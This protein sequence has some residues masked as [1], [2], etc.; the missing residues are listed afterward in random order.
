[1]FYD[2]KE[3]KTKKSLHDVSFPS[4]MSLPALSSDDAQV[5]YNNPTTTTTTTPA[6]GDNRDGEKEEKSE[7]EP[8]S[9]EENSKRHYGLYGVLVHSGMTAN[10]G[11][12]FSFCRESSG[13]G[14]ELQDSLFAPWI[15]F[16]D[17]KVETSSWAEMNRILS[18]SVS[19]TVYLLLYK[20]IE[21]PIVLTTTTATT[22][23]STAVGATPIE[24]D[25]AMLLAKAMALS[26][27]AAAQKTP[28]AQ[29]QQ[30]LM[31]DIDEENSSTTT[32]L[33][34]NDTFGIYD[35]TTSISREVMYSMI[36]YTHY[37]L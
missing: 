9:K 11:H 28:K 34:N 16:N 27:S 29:D 15:K 33:H 6:S 37:L 13:K 21:A 25:E 24:E 14:L 8:P 3:Q 18:N 19:D 4:Y 23:T 31:M 22:A 30:A 26:M 10:S 1:M 7:E 17:T 12:Y 36:S 5:V 2:W 20:R 32:T 35:V